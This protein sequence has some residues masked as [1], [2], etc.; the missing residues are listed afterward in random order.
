MVADEAAAN[1]AEASTS[2][3]APR[4]WSWS[5]GC[6]REASIS[7]FVLVCMAFGKTLEEVGV[8]FGVTRER[9]RQLQNLALGKLRQMLEEDLE[10]MGVAA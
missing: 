7:G 6:G 8:K 1:P 10:A 2:H 3:H 4:C 9:I 5:R